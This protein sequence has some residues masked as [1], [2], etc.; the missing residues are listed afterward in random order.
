MKN[1]MKYHSR[2][3]HIG[4]TLLELLIA[5]AIVGI[6]TAVALPSYQQSRFKTNRSDAHISLSSLATMQERY[7]FTNN[8]YTGDFANLINGHTSGD[9]LD[10]DDGH[11]SIT[12]A[13]TG[14]GSGWTM[15]ATAQ[16]TQAGDT[17]CA[18]LTTTSLGVK[19]AAD[20]GANDTT[21]Q[22]W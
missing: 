13:A 1:N 16:G 20:S 7:F 11:Y 9:P 4:F 19:S 10:S 15:T 12:V 22:C 18:T 6:L 2:N 5:I 17:T 14:G 8:A 21:A 3:R